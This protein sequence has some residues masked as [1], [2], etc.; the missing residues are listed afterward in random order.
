VELAVVIFSIDTAAANSESFTDWAV[1]GVK[2]TLHG[3]VAGRLPR[4]AAVGRNGFGQAGYSICP[5]KGSLQH[6]GIVV[7]ALPSRLASK[8][9]FDPGA[10]R[11]Q[12]ERTAK[13][14]GL[15]GFYYQR[16]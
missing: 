1:A 7:Y 10:L 9:G 16:P 8:P 14:E 6:Y 4:E 13:S 5:P 11:T 2:P 3:I 15:L 12:A